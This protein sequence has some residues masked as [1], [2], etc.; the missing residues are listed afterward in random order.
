MNPSFGSGGTMAPPS[1]SSFD[2]IHA[3]QPTLTVGG[4]NLPSYGSIP[5]HSFLGANTQMGGFSTYYTPF[6]YPSSTMSVPM[7]TFPM[8]GPHISP[9]LSYKGNQFYG[10]SYPLHGTP[11][12]GEIYILT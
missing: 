6:V 2:R 10:S 5:S 8:V 4:W 9:G 1:T 11:S 12:H 3:P 7:K